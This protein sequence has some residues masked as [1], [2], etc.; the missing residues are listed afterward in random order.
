MSKKLAR[1]AILVSAMMLIIGIIPAMAQDRIVVVWYVGLGA[2]GQA[3]QVEAQNA[4]VEA[5]NASQESIELQLQI[6]DNNVAY[7]TLAT[8]IA[9]GQ[10]PGIVGPVGADGSNAFAGNYLNLDPLI[11]ASDYDISQF[12][13][14]SV[15]AFRDSEQGLIGLPFAT[16]PSFI[17]FRKGLF[18]EAGAPYPP[19]AY[20]ELYTDVNGNEVEW[21]MAALRDLAMYMTVDANGNDATMAEFDGETI[22]Q[23]GFVSQWNEARGISTMFGA[24]SLVDAEGNATLPEA[25]TNAFNWYYNGIWTDKFI[26]N[27]S[28]AGSDLL[29]N[30]NAFSSGRVAMAHTHLW[31]T[32]C[33]GEIN[34]W[35]LAIMPSFDGITTAKLHG[36]SFRLMRTSSD[37]SMEQQLAGFEVLT[38][39]IGE[40]SNELLLVYGGMP[41]RAEDTEGFFATLDENFTQGVNWQVAIDSLAYADSPNHE[42][43]MPNYL[44]AKDRI[45]AFQSLVESTPD[46]DVAAELATLVADLDII[47]NEE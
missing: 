45:G 21:D 27:A 35:D 30:G 15:E 40:A 25:W 11:E 22:E 10:A 44:K 36:D 28:Q 33:V 5:F 38:Y 3:E 32:C 24:T 43:N 4:V 23:W 41:A 19:Q 17:Y 26:P 16:F 29:A 18:D 20:G 47:F 7:D 9:T 1:L 13:P 6:V 14:A 12:S 8:L 42:Y 37:M 34:D 2:G 39:L 31:Y 46:L